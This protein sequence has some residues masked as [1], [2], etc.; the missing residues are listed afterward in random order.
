MENG[1]LDDVIRVQNT[2]SNTVIDAVVIGSGRVE[3]QLQQPL[4]MRTE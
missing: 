2:Q 1:A 3:V 4:A